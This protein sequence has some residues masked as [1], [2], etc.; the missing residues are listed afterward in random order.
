MRVAH[1]RSSAGVARVRIAAAMTIDAMIVFMVVPLPEIVNE[2]L[3]KFKR[4][5]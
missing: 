1:S 2:L 3:D 5:R 4:M